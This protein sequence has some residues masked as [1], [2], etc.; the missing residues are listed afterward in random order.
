MSDNLRTKMIHLAASLPKGSDRKA[1]LDVLAAPKM[2]KRLDV[3][4]NAYHGGMGGDL[5]ITISQ[6]SEAIT[7]SEREWGRALDEARDEIRQAE[8]E[9]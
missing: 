1:L 9:W 3:G 4:T 5:T 8:R 6:G 7:A 2:A